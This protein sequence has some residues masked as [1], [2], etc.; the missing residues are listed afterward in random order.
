MSGGR[1]GGKPR[2]RRRERR[3]GVEIVELVGA[4][5]TCV[6]EFGAVQNDMFGITHLATAAIVVDE[7]IDEF[8]TRGE[9]NRE[10]ETGTY[11][12]GGFGVMEEVT[13]DAAVSLEGAGFESGVGQPMFG[14]RGG[15]NGEKLL[16]VQGKGRGRRKFSFCDQIL[17]RKSGS[18]KRK[19][20]EWGS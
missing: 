17:G 16:F 7:T 12:H 5:V 2:T 8:A 1:G 3:T 6:R 14:H 4:V 9:G 19:Q 20:C 13:R 18:R 11:A 10:T 15:S